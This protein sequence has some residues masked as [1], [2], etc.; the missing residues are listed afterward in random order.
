MQHQVQLEDAYRDHA[1]RLQEQRVKFEAQIAEIRSRYEQLLRQRPGH[2]HSEDLLLGLGSWSNVSS[3]SAEASKEDPGQ[4]A[5]FWLRI[6]YQ[7]RAT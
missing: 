2:G 7:S 6:S 5:G 4:A 3:L 1:S